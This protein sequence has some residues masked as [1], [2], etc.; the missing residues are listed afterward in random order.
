MPRII[1]PILR[2]ARPWWLA[3]LLTL[4][5]ACS[6]PSAEPPQTAESPP[7]AALPPAPEIED[8]GDNT[9]RFLVIGRQ[10]VLKCRGPVT[11]RTRQVVY[12][13][14]ICE[15][16]FNPEPYVIADAHMFADGHRI[17][18]VVAGFYETISRPV[19]A[20]LTLELRFQ[21]LGVVGRNGSG[22][23]LLSRLVAGLVVP[24]LG[25]IRI[26]G[27]D[28]GRDRRA[29]LGSAAV[30]AEGAGSARQRRRRA[31]RDDHRGAEAAGEGAEGSGGGGCAAGPR[32]RER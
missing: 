1:V 22:K 6:P 18:A 10:A 31:D 5:S 4:L 30:A 7:T 8:L 13:V 26:A 17:E 14:E 25:E 24:D 27:I 2:S 11:P 15:L 19:L 9:T 23:S 21:W 12:E 29:G 16:G 32:R 28:P 20:D 3:I